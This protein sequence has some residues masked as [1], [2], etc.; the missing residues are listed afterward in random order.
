MPLLLNNSTV[1][2]YKRSKREYEFLEF[3]PI[4]HRWHSINAPDVDGVHYIYQH[5]IIGRRT[6]LTLHNGRTL[7]IQV[8]LRL[9]HTTSGQWLPVLN[10]DQRSRI[11]NTGSTV[12]QH[13]TLDEMQAP[14]NLNLGVWTD[15]QQAPVPVPAPAPPAAP[16]PVAPPAAPVEN[17]QIPFI[18]PNVFL[19]LS[20]NVSN[21]IR[22]GLYQSFINNAALCLNNHSLTNNQRLKNLSV[23]FIYGANEVITQYNK[24]RPIPKDIASLIAKNAE[25][26]SV[27]CPITMDPINSN[28]CSVTSCYHLFD[29]DAINTWLNSNP[30]CPICKQTCSEVPILEHL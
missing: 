7:H 28:N 6:F 13:S 11:V 25:T 18:N 30:S 21:S 5:Q 29:T 24:L 15:T 16:V 14:A 27:I 22:H 19:N 23:S 2:V 17:H 12:V 20:D 9:L 26:N 10:P 4:S 1:A 3:E 8:G